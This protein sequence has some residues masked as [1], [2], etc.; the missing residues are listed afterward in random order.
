MS[1]PATRALSSPATKTLH[2]GNTDNVATDAKQDATQKTATDPS[3]TPT[4]SLA[5]RAIKCTGK[6]LLGVFTVPAMAA[7]VTITG[8]ISAIADS[9]HALVEPVR[10]RTLIGAFVISITVFPVLS[11]I[12]GVCGACNGLFDGI[13]K[14][15]TM[16]SEFSL[17]PLK[18]VFTDVKKSVSGEFVREMANKIKK[19][20]EY[21]DNVRKLANK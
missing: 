17:D 16:A 8:L 2:S 13:S 12:Y 9:Y 20:K 6:I 1:T 18:T 3:K 4:T 11:A 21:Q 15:A 10:K 7:F 5:V 14:G 19:E